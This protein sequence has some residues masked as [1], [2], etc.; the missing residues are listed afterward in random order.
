MLDIVPESRQ[1]ARIPGSYPLPPSARVV[2]LLLLLL[3]HFS[4]V[5]LLATSWT[6]AHQAP[7]SMGFSRQEYWSGVPLSSPQ[8]WC[9]GQGTE[10]GGTG[11]KEIQQSLV[12]SQEG[13]TGRMF[14]EDGNKG[15]LDGG[16]LGEL[17]TLCS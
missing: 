16:F 4:R 13:W 17:I 8:G 5:R 3:S 12:S 15:E 11:S 9:W 1:S 6:A 14:P 10:P 7:P 2:V